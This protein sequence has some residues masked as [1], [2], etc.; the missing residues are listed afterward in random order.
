MG[1]EM[2]VWAQSIL[3]IDRIGG[4]TMINVILGFGVMR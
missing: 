3:E 1:L 2:F 4:E